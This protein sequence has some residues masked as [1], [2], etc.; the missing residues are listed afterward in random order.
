M[1]LNDLLA[2]AE[3]ASPVSDEVRIAQ[4][5]K[6]VERTL[7]VPA[8]ELGTLEMRDSTPTLVFQHEGAEHTLTWKR[9][10]MGNII[11]TLD[12]R[13]QITFSGDRQKDMRRLQE[14]LSG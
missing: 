7:G 2:Q 1:P 5:E 4:M 11:W 8:S 3:P 14:A 10:M 9:E 13:K 12:S 6:L